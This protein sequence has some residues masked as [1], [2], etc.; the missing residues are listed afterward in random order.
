LNSK[1]CRHKGEPEKQL[2]VHR[3]IIVNYDKPGLGSDLKTPLLVPYSQ[4]YI[5]FATYESAQ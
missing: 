1:N 4:H 3:R 2:S 5:F